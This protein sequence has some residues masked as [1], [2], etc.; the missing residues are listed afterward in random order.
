[1]EDTYWYLDPSIS[2]WP[3]ENISQ[4][5]EPMKKFTD[6]TDQSRFERALSVLTLLM[7]SLSEDERIRAA[8]IFAG[9][10]R[11]DKEL[12]PAQIVEA[13]KAAGEEMVY[14]GREAEANGYDLTPT[15]AMVWAVL[16]ALKTL[17]PGHMV[18][19][20]DAKS[21]SDEL[22]ALADAAAP[23][24]GLLFRPTWA[25]FP[26]VTGT[27]TQTYPTVSASGTSN[28]YNDPKRY[29]SYPDMQDAADDSWV[30]DDSGLDD[31]QVL[32]NHHYLQG[33]VKGRPK[34]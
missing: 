8:V 6:V 30:M 17:L 7:P 29:V 33:K 22:V 27:T 16:A 4:G 34:S 20:K 11:A 3:P 25:P 23:V 15:E 5:P 14:R 31:W 2:T 19:G 12:T 24:D 26:K 1:M 9:M 18:T 21:I 32:Q 10:D 13:A 28:S